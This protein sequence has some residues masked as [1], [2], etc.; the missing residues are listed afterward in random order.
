[1]TDWLVLLGTGRDLYLEVGERKSGRS[2]WIAGVGLQTTDAA[3][4][5]NS[6]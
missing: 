3:E 1:M 5:W 6:G 4:E 2:R